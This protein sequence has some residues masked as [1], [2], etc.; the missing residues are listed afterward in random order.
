MADRESSLLTPGIAVL[1][2]ESSLRMGG[3]PAP[4]PLLPDAPSS[5]GAGLAADLHSAT[6]LPSCPPAGRTPP[7]ASAAAAAAAARLPVGNDDARP[8]RPP[9]PVVCS[10]GAAAVRSHAIPRATTIGVKGAQCTA[11]VR[12]VPGAGD[13]MKG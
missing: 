2:P 11:A 7:K 6:L 8:P 9:P 1:I 4:S 3:A 13:G 12:C 10:T 5:P